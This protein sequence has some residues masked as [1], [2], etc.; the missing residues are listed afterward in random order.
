MKVSIKLTRKYKTS[1][2]KEPNC[3]CFIIWLQNNIESRGLLV[4]ETNYFEKISVFN[5]YI[6]HIKKLKITS[7]AKCNRLMKTLLHA[8][9]FLESYWFDI[10][11]IQFMNCL[12]D[13]SEQ[14][15]LTLFGYLLYKITSLISTF[16]AM[17]SPKL[18]KL[19]TYI[20]NL[21]VRACFEG[22]PLKSEV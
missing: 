4:R 5:V 12:M 11:L 10:I 7:P 2:Y 8:V 16:T 18:R 19:T 1:Q 3:F 22:K 6:T 17:F 15:N 13:M 14:I 20:L 21:K 9:S